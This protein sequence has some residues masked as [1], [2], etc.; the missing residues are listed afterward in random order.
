MTVV[1]RLAGMLQ[2]R[3]ASSFFK[4]PLIV[5]LF[6][7]S[8]VCNAWFFIVV[9]TPLGDGHARYPLLSQRIF[10]QQPNDTIINFTDLRSQLRSFVPAQ[11]GLHA[12]VYFEYLPSGVSIGVN[13]KDNFISASLIKVPLIMGIFKLMETGTLQ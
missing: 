9:F 2:R 8:V 3:P 4:I 5:V 12:G 11:K 13:E 7:L 10:V 1:E 6:I